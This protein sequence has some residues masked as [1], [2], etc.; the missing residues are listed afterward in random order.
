MTQ[1]KYILPKSEAKFYLFSTAGLIFSGVFFIYRKKKNLDKML[2][3][4][5]TPIFEMYL[6]K[7]NKSENKIGINY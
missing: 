4:K 1:F 2:D 6:N 7:I 5:Y 3:R